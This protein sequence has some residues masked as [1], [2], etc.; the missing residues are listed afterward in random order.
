M[1]KLQFL[2]VLLLLLLASG[3]AW[4][5]KR[6]ALVIGNGAYPSVGNLDNPPND[7]KLM[8]RTLSPLLPPPLGRNEEK[9]GADGSERGGVI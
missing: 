1:T 9:Y 2:A 3:H 8:A 6:V 7:A 5:E 4:A